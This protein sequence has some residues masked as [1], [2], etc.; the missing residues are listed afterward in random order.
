MNILIRGGGD[1]GSGVAFRLHRVG[2]NVVITEIENPLVLRRTVSFANAIYENVV[3]VE[4]IKAR[5]VNDARGIPKL[6][7]KHEIP[8]LISP[9]KY[10]FS[11]YMPDVIVDARL[12]KKFD[13][14][15]LRTKP[16]VIGLGPGFKVGMNCHVVIETKRGHYLG[17]A[18]W[19]GEAISDTGI[20]GTV[21]QKSNERVLRAPASGYIQ[22]N[23]KLGT[24]YKKGDLIGNVANKPILASF[25][26][27]LRGLMHDGIYVEE[28]TKIGDLDPRLDK[29]LINFISEKS[30]AIAGGV[31]EAILTYQNTT[32]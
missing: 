30:L 14:Y 21:S 1:L 12:L 7:D 28:G 20:P 5:Y 6:I 4:G 10:S 22:S 24:F 3:N 17:R 29:D 16:M 8:V 2:W 15:Q 25:E 19:K 23:A 27:C 26:G 32:K 13:E 9:D 11:E 18:L 31:L